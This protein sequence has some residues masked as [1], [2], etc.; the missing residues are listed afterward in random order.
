MDNSKAYAEQLDQ[1]DSLKSFKDEF[2]IPEN[3]LYMDGNSL[4]LLSRRAE[5]AVKEVIDDWKTY[6]IDGW[7]NGNHPWFYM[8][9]KL[10]DNTA[11]LVGALPH[12]VV[13]TGSTTVNLHQLVSTFYQP[14]E[15][16]NKILA[17]ELN[18]PSDIYALKS[19][20]QLHGFSH[21]THLVQTKS[22]NGR[23][24]EEQN[25]VDAMNNDIA[26]IVLP[27]V[28]YRSGQLLDIRR[29]TEEAH[30]RNIMIGIDAC[31]SIGA[32]PHQFH[33]D[34]VDFAFWCNYKYLNNGPGGTA[35]L[36]VHEKHLGR[37]PGLA[38]WFGSDK[39][40]QFDME[41]EFTPAETAGAFQ[42]GTP[43]I[44]STAPLIGSLDIFQEAGI[45]NLR[46][47]SLALTRYLMK[48][49]DVELAGMNFTIGN[50]VEDN[51]RGG[52]ICLEHREAAR[53]C[54]ALKWNGVIPDF[55][56]PNVIR[57][58]PIALYSSFTDVWNT[59]HTLKKIMTEKQYEQFENK[60]DVIA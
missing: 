31:H 41:H 58:A 35:G 22:R 10:A 18:F 4:G 59:V 26:L 13:V 55:R 54:K 56:A 42:I 48:L 32:V 2:Y 29:L 37:Q 9:E 57:L 24:L 43:H 28:L 6:A 50:P 7:T 36:Y 38:G 23:T 30:K 16:R 45:T 12:E 46:R 33:D 60:R 14:E 44:L 5:Q 11:P 3:T 8:S 17:D 15:D 34:E 25:I 53:I 27:A 49:I 21:E 52:H 51:R 40:K 39:Q 20:L 19:Q 47:K 1:E